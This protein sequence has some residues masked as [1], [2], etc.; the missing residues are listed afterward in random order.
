VNNP[1]PPA[2]SDDQNNND[3]LQSNPDIPFQSTRETVPHKSNQEV[4]EP[5]KSYKLNSKESRD[6]GRQQINEHINNYAQTLLK[7]GMKKREVDAKVK[8]LFD[9]MK[10]A[11]RESTE[12]GLYGTELSAVET[13][14][15][16]WLWQERI[17]L[18][19][20]TVLEGDPGWANH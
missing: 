14:Q 18:G 13:H 15:I 17:P 7:L 12:D 10:Q 20:I 4:D 2:S 9:S 16:E 8:K 6:K 3:P 5:T 19:K 1:T 11:I